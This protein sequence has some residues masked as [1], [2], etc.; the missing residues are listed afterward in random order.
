MK[1]IKSHGRMSHQP[2]A[3][4]EPQHR[5]TEQK[6]AKLI[7]LIEELRRDLPNVNNRHD[8]D[9]TLLKKSMHPDLVIAALD[10]RGDAD[11]QV[12]SAADGKVET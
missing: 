4:A 1:R 12:K 5:Q 10:K 9:A 3:A 2:A 7:D 11:G 6:A 8:P